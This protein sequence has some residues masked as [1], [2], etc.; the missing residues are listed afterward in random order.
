MNSDRKKDLNPPR[1]PEWLIRRLAWEEDQFSILE[2]L[3]EE[4]TYIITT[5]GSRSADL[6][7][8]GHM[9]RSLFPFVKFSIYWRFV[10][11]KNYLKVALRN[12]YK[13]KSYYFINISGLAIG[14]ACCMLIMLWVQDE[15]DYERFNENI[16]DIFCL[17]NY[18]PENPNSYNDS[19][20]APLIPYLKDKY[21]EI[22]NASRFKASS[23]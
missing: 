14:M 10:M 6:W 19:V 4:Y 3:R 11:F 5:R 22:K 16:D 8:W 13:N 20:P 17:V 18:P 1:L 2:N 15:L 12:F 23:G 9:F 7:Y 21:A